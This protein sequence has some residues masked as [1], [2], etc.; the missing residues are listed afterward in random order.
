MN[1]FYLMILNLLNKSSSLV[2]L[3]FHYFV[4]SPYILMVMKKMKIKGTKKQMS[5]RITSFHCL[6]SN[7]WA[8]SSAW[9]VFLLFQQ[10]Q[11][12]WNTKLKPWKWLWQLFQVPV[13]NQKSN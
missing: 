4:C 5:R 11:D 13:S 9:H 7:Q 10:L 8:Q 3:L 1:L 6:K 2:Q 12:S